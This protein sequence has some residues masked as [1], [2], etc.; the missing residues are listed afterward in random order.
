MYKLSVS[1]DKLKINSIWP[2]QRY[3]P[4]VDTNRRH[5]THIQTLWIHIF[6]NTNSDLNVKKYKRTTRILSNIFNVHL[7]LHIII[8]AHND[9]NANEEKD[10]KKEHEKAAWK[11][12]QKQNGKNRNSFF[13]N[14]DFSIHQ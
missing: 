7:D 14:P 4:N 1:V 12:L 8:F 9:A 11:I 5:D 10:W 3:Q 6:N 2:S 13:N